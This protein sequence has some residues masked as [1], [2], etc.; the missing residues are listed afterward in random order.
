MSRSGSGISPSGALTT[1]IGSG[2]AGRGSGASSVEEIV[3]PKGKKGQISV[4]GN[5]FVFNGFNSSITPVRVS[6]LVS[7]IYVYVFILELS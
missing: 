6:L 4:G 3:T 5:G 1:A 2:M 7:C